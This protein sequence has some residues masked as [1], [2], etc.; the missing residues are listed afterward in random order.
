MYDY[1]WQII[2]RKRLLIM[3]IILNN[4][5]AE[6]KCHNSYNLNS[7][8]MSY[9]LRMLSALFCTCTLYSWFPILIYNEERIK[10]K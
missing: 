10:G 6:S 3:N 5:I 1:F 2:F 4:R 9:N 8:D 7:E